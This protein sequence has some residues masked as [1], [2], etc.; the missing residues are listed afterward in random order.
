M[1]TIPNIDLFPQGDPETVVVL[2][3]GSLI[4][5]YIRGLYGHVMLGIREDAYGRPVSC[6]VTDELYLDTSKPLRNRWGGA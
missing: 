6:A 4:G 5:L 1:E 2:P 3:H